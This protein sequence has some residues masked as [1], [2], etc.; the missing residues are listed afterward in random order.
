MAADDRYSRKVVRR[1]ASALVKRRTNRLTR[2]CLIDFALARFRLPRKSGFSG[3]ERQHMRQCELVLGIRTLFVLETGEKKKKE[4]Y[5]DLAQ[6]RANPAK[7]PVTASPVAPP[8]RRIDQSQELHNCRAL[9]RCSS[10]SLRSPPQTAH[11]FRCSHILAPLLTHQ[12]PFESGL[13][14][15]AP[16]RM[17]N[18]SPKRHRRWHAKN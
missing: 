1:Y 10:S 18:N 3:S 16:S 13:K 11:S 12:S 14:K 15:F 7:F 5:S 2:R 17:Q 6:N 9:T 4:S 8:R